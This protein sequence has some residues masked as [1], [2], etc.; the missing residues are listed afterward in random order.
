MRKHSVRGARQF[1]SSFV[2]GLASTTEVSALRHSES[3]IVEDV[4]V[5]AILIPSLSIRTGECRLLLVDVVNV[6][7]GERT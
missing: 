7:E 2:S 5:A 6:D 4:R 3:S 1:A